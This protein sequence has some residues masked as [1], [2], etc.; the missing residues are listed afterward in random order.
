[1]TVTALHI[2]LSAQEPRLTAILWGVRV[3]CSSA[4]RA[5]S[6]LA[7]VGW[8]GGSSTLLLCYSKRAY[9][10][11]LPFDLTTGEE[12][13]LCIAV[14]PDQ[15]DRCYKKWIAPWTWQQDKHAWPLRG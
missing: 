4:L 6:S 5:P 13:D 11:Q 9:T 2:F 1:M 7:D 10:R 12:L 8:L 14:K 15:L 3:W